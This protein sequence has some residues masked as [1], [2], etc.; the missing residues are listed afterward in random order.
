MTLDLKRPSNGSRTSLPKT[1]KDTKKVH[2][3]SD[4]IK[5]AEQCLQIGNNFQTLADLEDDDMDIQ[6]LPI[7]TKITP[8]LLPDDKFSHSVALPWA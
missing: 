1:G 3:C 5:K 2:V 6:M 7:K 8:I 4:R